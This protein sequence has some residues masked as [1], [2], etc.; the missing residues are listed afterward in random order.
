MPRGAAATPLGVHCGA[1]RATFCRRRTI[2]LLV[3]RGPV[4]VCRRFLLKFARFQKRHPGAKT[5]YQAAKTDYQAAKTDY[6]A[7]K[8]DYQAAKTDYQAA[9]SHYGRAEIR[10]SGFVVA[11]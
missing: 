2:S 4:T 1:A 3:L 5:D 7:A 11:F 8:I 10:R 9:K 6:Q